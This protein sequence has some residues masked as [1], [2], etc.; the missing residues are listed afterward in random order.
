MAKKQNEAIISIIV[1]KETKE[2]FERISKSNK[3][4]SS[5]QGALLIEKYLRGEL[6]EMD[7]KRS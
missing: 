1:D 3:R 4:S 7:N 5:K 2:E 6:Y